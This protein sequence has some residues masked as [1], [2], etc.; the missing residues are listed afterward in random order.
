M[1]RMRQVHERAS[2]VHG[3]Q[4]IR[5]RASIAPLVSP[6]KYQ[7]DLVLERSLAPRSSTS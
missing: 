6:E 1:A 3:S 4:V 5:A 7:S 2:G